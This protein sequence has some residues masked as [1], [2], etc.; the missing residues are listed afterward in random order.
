MIAGALSMGIG[1]RELFEDYYFNE[2][3]PIIEAYNALHR[4]C[5]NAEE[6]M[7]PLAFMGTGGE[8]IS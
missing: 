6:S 8:W 5:D 3:S 2:L 7:E 4:P 1:K